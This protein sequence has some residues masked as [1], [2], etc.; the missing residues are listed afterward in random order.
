MTLSESYQKMPNIQRYIVL[1]LNYGS[2][3]T[4]AC[5]MINGELIA[6]CE[7]ERFNKQK[8]TKAFPSDSINDCLDQA[9]ISL[10]DVD[11]IAFSFDQGLLKPENYDDLD[12]DLKRRFTRENLNYLRNLRA[13]DADIA[14][15]IRDTL[16]FSGKITT[17][18]HHLTHLASAYYPS[19]FND[20]L[21]M[22]HDGV[23]EICCSLLATAKDGDITIKHHGNPWPESL[24][25]LYAAVTQYLGWRYA[26]DEGI[27]MGL[28]PLG[29][30]TQQVE[31]GA[32]SYRD[33]FQ[34]I[35]YAVNDFEYEINKDWIA[36]HKMRSKWVSDKFV[37][38][39]GPR[40]EP[41]GAISEHHKNVAAA[42]QN[43]V[44]EI[45]LQ[46]LRIAREKFNLNKLCFSGG[47]ALNCSLNGKIAESKIFDEIFV[48]P[49]S[50]DNGTAI[51]ASY[52][53]TKK[54]LPDL[55]SNRSHNYYKG[56]KF[57]NDEIRKALVAKEVDYVA[58]ENFSDSVAEHLSQQRI[59]G[60]FQGGAEFGP[61]ALGNRSILTSPFPAEMKDILNT[62]VKFREIF[63]PF[64][65]AILAEYADEYFNIDQPSP[66]ML[67]AV[68]VKTDKIDA[69]PSAIHV[70]NSA[71]VQTVSE[72]D[73]PK[74]RSLLK[75]FNAKTQCPVILN[76]S[77]N[78]KGQPIV[79]TPEDAIDCFFST[80]I[81]VLAIGDF[82]VTKPSQ[83]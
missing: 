4:S 8:H 59:V 78:V 53:A 42:L 64:A 17:H 20:A 37:E 1:G 69:I 32:G 73:N 55:K 63:R 35:V 11:E 81:D 48:Q 33:F 54:A 19:G 52:L 40:R 26:S 23:G 7:E 75:A 38:T 28:A 71:R 24:G 12:S 66:H 10:A 29:D 76:T 50:G 2:H 56:S 30:D 21:L 65:P 16:N 39:F 77:F 31:S 68:S 3:D 57:S 72:S 27:V 62:R 83:E 49:A 45:V 47:L 6:A 41:E 13:K 82:I 14:A 9:G 25:L 44:E 61:R 70:D 5:V 22:S 58:P 51:G 80:N 67:I 79:N 60:W 74:F 18:L 15:T 46:Q 34:E 43:R 36:F